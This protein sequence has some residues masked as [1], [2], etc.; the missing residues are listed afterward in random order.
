M[1]SPDEVR[2]V[3]ARESLTALFIDRHGRVEKCLPLPRM[4]TA[5]QIVELSRS[6]PGYALIFRTQGSYAESEVEEWG[7]S[8]LEG[9]EVLESGKLPPG[10]RHL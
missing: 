5:E 9:R 7:R 10:W 2:G 4:P 3:L 6:H 8:A 1:M